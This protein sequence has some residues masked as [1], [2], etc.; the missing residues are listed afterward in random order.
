MI[1]ARARGLVGA[2]LGVAAYLMATSPMGGALWAVAVLVACS[3]YGGVVERIARR[4]LSP[5]MLVVTGLA[6]LL[7]LS[8]LV[9]RAGLLVP[10][11]QLAF[12]AVGLVACAIPRHAGER[13]GFAIPRSVLVLAVAGGALLV[14]MELVHPASPLVDEAANHVLAVK[15]LWDTGALPASLAHQLGAQVIGESYF[16]LS[17]GAHLA[18][19]FDGGICVA[20][21]VLLLA[22]LVAADGVGLVVF[23]LLA[24]PLVLNPDPRASEALRWSSTL[25]HLATWVALSRSRDRRAGLVAIAP[26]IA[27]AMLHHELAILAA[28]YVVVAVWPRLVAHERTRR[29]LAIVTWILQP[30]RDRELVGIAILAGLVLAIAMVTGIVPPATRGLTT[31]FATWYP[32]AVLVVIQ[33]DARFEVARLPSLIVLAFLVT[34][35]VFGPGFNDARRARVRERFM[36]AFNDLEFVRLHGY[37]L[38]AHQGARALQDRIAPGTRIGF[39]GES[40]AALDHARNPIIDLSFSGRRKSTYLAPLGAARIG[41]LDYVLVEDLTRPTPYVMWGDGIGRPLEASLPL[42]L[43][44]RSGTIVLFRVTR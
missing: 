29:V 9:A 22:E 27:L 17:T 14:G 42:A 2:L 31:S 34:V 1:L 26:A 6:V 21:L 23:V 11:A 7:A 36:H 15:H 16:A 20:L 19:V 4:R 37:D 41:A 24:I 33:L 30:R 25:L 40:A 10:R 44:A 28:L 32:V 8:T 38:T 13:I 5:I 43:V 35:M 3:G 12:V 18:A 39:W